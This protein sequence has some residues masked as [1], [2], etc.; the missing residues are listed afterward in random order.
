MSG[1]NPFRGNWA[2]SALTRLGPDECQAAG[3]DARAKMTA[4]L[5]QNL[6]E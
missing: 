5:G 4:L 2:A 3:E 6:P 1:S